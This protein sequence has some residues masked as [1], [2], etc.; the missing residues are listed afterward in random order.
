M[1]TIFQSKYWKVTSLARK[2]LAGG[3]ILQGARTVVWHIAG[4][5]VEP[6][7]RV[8]W[9][10]GAGS[11]LPG[12]TVEMYLPCRLCSNCRRHRQ[13]RWTHKAKLECAVA[14]RNWFGTLTFDPDMQMQI[15]H[16]ARSQ[17]QKKSRDFDEGS[18][19][20]QFIGLVASA[21][22]FVTLWLKRVRKLSKAQFRYILVAE[23][24]K[25]GKPHYHVIIHEKQGSETIPHRVLTK[26]WPHGFTK[27]NLVGD[28]SPKQTAAYVCKYIGKT[29]ACR[30][31]ASLGYGELQFPLPLSGSGFSKRK[32]DPPDTG[33]ESEACSVDPQKLPFLVTDPSQMEMGF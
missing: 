28:G 10:V 20:E 15:L 6:V 5:C 11:H 21:S 22:R 27:F 2:A 1:S 17:A 9:T 31:R 23:P 32:L 13:M 16:L 8:Q 26:A 29:A 33:E 25:S 7:L 12:V 3:A 4:R 18:P 30:V 14:A 24:H 19:R